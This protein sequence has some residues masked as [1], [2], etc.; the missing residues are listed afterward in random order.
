MHCL[1]LLW[2]GFWGGALFCSF[3][4]LRMGAFIVKQILWEQDSIWF[5]HPVGCTDD[6]WNILISDL[7]VS[8][9]VW[10][11][12]MQGFCVDIVP[13]VDQ[14]VWLEGEDKLKVCKLLFKTFDFER[15][16]ARYHS[17]LPIKSRTG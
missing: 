13:F 5:W 6:F 4:H 2:F 17:V 9:F 11:G 12:T 8:V 15:T 3:F 16:H 14:L 7:H 1:K 10:F